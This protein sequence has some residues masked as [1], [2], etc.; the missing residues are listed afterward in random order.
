MHTT[1]ASC[2]DSMA[3]GDASDGIAGHPVDLQGGEW[4]TAGLMRDLSNQNGWG[5]GISW[6]KYVCY[7]YII[8]IY[9]IYIYG[10]LMV[11]DHQALGRLFFDIIP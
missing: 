9:N 4:E 11:Y 6:K 5:I 7:I 3:A 10:K 8:N 1:L 2:K